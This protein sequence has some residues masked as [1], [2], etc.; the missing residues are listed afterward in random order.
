MNLRVELAV[1]ELLFTLMP[2]RIVIECL[3]HGTARIGED[4]GRAEV[5]G[6]NVARY[7]VDACPAILEWLI[8]CSTPAYRR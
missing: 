5:I 3:D 8:N 1:L 2:T 4:I 7:G 6:M